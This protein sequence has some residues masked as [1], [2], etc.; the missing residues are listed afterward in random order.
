MTTP[1]DG[2]APDVTPSQPTDPSP[3]PPPTNQPPAY[4]QPP[5]F[6]SVGGES[7]SPTRA[8]HQPAFSYAGEPPPSTTS[9]TPVSTE[10]VASDGSARWR[11]IAA[12]L[13]TVL[14]VAVVI[15]AFLLLGI[16]PSATPSLVAQYVPA[17]SEAYV[18]IRLDLPGDQRDRLAEFM[19]RFPG[20]ADQAS[21]EQK[22]DETL[23]NIFNSA[24]REREVEWERDVQPWFGGMVGLALMSIDP[25]SESEYS[26]VVVFSVTDRAKL[27]ELIAA[28]GGGTLQTEEYQGS[29]IYQVAEAPDGRPFNF[30]PTADAVLASPRLE[31]L[32]AALDA[33]AGDTQGLADDSFFTAQLAELSADYLGLFYYDYSDVLN[34]M[35]VPSGLPG[36][37]P[38]NCMPDVASAR[39][40]TMLGAVRAEA[41]HMSLEVRASAPQVE[42]FPQFPNRTSNLVQS[43]PADTVF[44]LES[45]AIGQS[46]K[47][48]VSQL[49]DCLPSDGT[50]FSPDQLGQMLGTA[51]EDYFDFL[52]DL[53]VGVTLREGKFGG[54][55]IATVN[56][57]AVARV[58]LERLLSAVRLAAGAG[59]GITVEE[60]QHGDATLTVINL[61]D[62]LVP[63]TD[64][65][66]FRVTV[67]R[68]RL[69]MGADDF[70]T[71]ALDQ[72]EADSL[73]SAPRLQ[74]A[75]NATSSENAGLLYVDVA[76][77][78]GSV[79]GVIPSDER[80]EYDTEVKP[81]LEPMTRLVMVGRN[82]QGIYS[83]NVFLYVE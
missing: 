82:D 77:L 26:G 48:Y 16:R 69:Y 66:S 45:R 71:R 65:P 42:G 9:P 36:M 24:G 6:P 56:D 38:E 35:P 41:D 25:E 79:E 8:E 43:M 40:V 47:Y 7:D 37:F 78:R 55:L 54:G 70:V 60:Q 18:E 22:L 39:D 14:L 29:T 62:D 17:G 49:L 81:F 64:I 61:G 1:R 32:K 11:W 51:P 19:S 33:Q 53:A 44:Y 4:Q 59:A 57:E 20:F 10:P 58:R 28:R 12:G 46:I 13:A 27:D 75:L 30:V 68:G 52:E 3:A 15:G 34:E 76:A 83:S 21:F 72:G 23:A 67:A 31:D 74:S 63:G 2:W 73:A 80:S 50:G 5:V